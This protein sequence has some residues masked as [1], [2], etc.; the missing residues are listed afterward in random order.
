MNLTNTTL[1]TD[2]ERMQALEYLVSRYGDVQI[3]VWR[4][5]E[6]MGMNLRAVIRDQ[7]RVLVE[8]D[9]MYVENCIDALWHWHMTVGVHTHHPLG[10]GV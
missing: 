7:D 3:M 5:P 9:R 1:H 6:L 2:D 4:T 10:V 8:L